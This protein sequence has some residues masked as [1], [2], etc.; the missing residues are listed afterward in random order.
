MKLQR[1]NH[2]EQKR[3]LKFRESVRYGPI[4]TCTVC[5]QDMFLSNVVILTNEFK[6][7]VREKDFELYLLAFKTDHPIE[8]W[9][10]SNPDETTERKCDSYICF[11]C[12]KHLKMGK[13]PPMAA[14]NGLDIYPIED[15]SIKLSELENNLIAK[16][17]I[18]QKIFQLPKSRMAACKDRLI[19]I[20]ITSEDIINTLQCLPRTPKEAG[21]LEVKLKRK[22]EYQNVHKQA[23][24]DPDKIFKAL[25]FLKN[26]GHPDYEFYDDCSVY[27][28]RC[29]QTEK[30]EITFV[31]DD[32]VENILEKEKYIEILDNGANSEEYSEEEEEV[33]RKKDVIRKHQ[34]DYDASVCLVDKYP[35]AAITEEDCN[36]ISFAP[37]EG[38]VPQNILNSKNWD[39]QAFP[40][41]HPDGKNSLQQERCRI[42][43]KDT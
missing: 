35:E 36:Q 8:I 29:K 7:E 21:L 26:C 32:Y 42:R 20:P 19:N 15:E 2:S 41:K 23:Y 18:F 10:C 11:T 40:M 13:L 9:L 14:S 22:L 30:V 38:K 39:I 17:I 27:Q 33:Y 28:R 6:N 16:K 34:F 4:F 12:K 25:E 24:I 3:L 1:N 37:G 43:N 31:D 5:E